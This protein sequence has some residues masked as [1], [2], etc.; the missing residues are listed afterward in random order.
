MDWGAVLI[1]SGRC[2]VYVLV[3][4]VDVQDDEVGIVIEK[5]ADQR[6]VIF[7]HALQCLC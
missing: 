1:T 3:E 5:D 2:C 7:A 6:Y 4:E